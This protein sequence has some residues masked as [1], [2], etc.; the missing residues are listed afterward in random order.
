MAKHTLFKLPILGRL[1]SAAGA[2]PIYRAVDSDDPEKTK[3]KNAIM[4]EN[5]GNEI[6]KGAG[7]Y[8]FPKGKTHSESNVHRAKT[9]A[10]RIML[11]ALRNAELN[12]HAKPNLIPVGLHYSN[13][14]KFRER[15]S[16]PRTA[17]ATS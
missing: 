9:G 6:S 7:C 12:G 14:Q 4:L 5:A 11:M 10:A 8:C 3:E 17:D 2:L 16:H 13:S 1:F 15:G